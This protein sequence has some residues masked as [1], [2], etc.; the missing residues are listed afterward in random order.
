MQ[1]FIRDP[2]RGTNILNLLLANDSTVIDF[3]NVVDCDHEALEF[4]LCLAFP[5]Q[6]TKKLA[7]R[8]LFN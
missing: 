8:V 3:G 5:M 4:S 6:A 7:N 2:T 1:Q